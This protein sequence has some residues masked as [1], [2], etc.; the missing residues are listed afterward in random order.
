MR[1]AHLHR[2]GSLFE[3]S[4]NLLLA[5]I[6]VLLLRRAGPPASV[7]RAGDLHSLTTWA[8]TIVLP[9]EIVAGQPFTFAV[10]GVDGRLASEVT[11][12][13]GDG[14][15]A[16]TDRTGRAT[17]HRA[18]RRP[19]FEGNLLLAKASGSSATTQIDPPPRRIHMRK[20]TSRGRLLA[21]PLFGMWRRSRDRCQLRPDQRRPRAGASCLAGVPRHSPGSSVSVQPQ[22]RYRRRPRRQSRLPSSSRSTWSCRVRRCFPERRAKL[23]FA[24][25]ARRKN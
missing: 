24:F 1:T 19:R 11:V 13:L 3:R 2:V 14:L 15:H 8:V 25:K 9:P 23:S 17:V 18:P 22:F 4:R 5:R 21:R 12:D 10:L 6:S 20:W 16:T 7:P